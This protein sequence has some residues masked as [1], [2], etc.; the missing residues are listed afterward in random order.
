MKRFALCLVTMVIL[1]TAVPAPAWSSG[2]RGSSSRGYTLIVA[3]ARYSVL[4]VAFDLVRRHS[5]VLVSYQGEGATPEPRLHVWNGTEWVKLTM[6]DYREVNFLQSPPARTVL[7]GDQQTLPAVLVDASTWSPEVVHITALETSALVNEFGRLLNFNAAEWKWFASRYNLE[8]RDENAE[9][10]TKSWYDQPGPL[11]RDAAAGAPEAI[12]PVHAEPA[13][14]VTAA[15][16]TGDTI[17]IEPIDAAGPD[18]DAAP[19]P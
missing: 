14:T 19:V 7:I 5:S 8:L 1:A 18:V 11:R 2:M 4:Q 12:E 16:A 6:T 3:P 17:I 9:R 13:E 10:R 15:E